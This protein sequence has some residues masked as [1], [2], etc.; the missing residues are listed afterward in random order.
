MILVTTV[1]LSLAY[2]KY[3]EQVL[4]KVKFKA[5]TPIRVHSN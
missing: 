3:V 1:I 2:Y 4:L 5:R